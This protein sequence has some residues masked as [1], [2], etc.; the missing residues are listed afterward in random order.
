MRIYDSK[1]VDAFIKYLN[2]LPGIEVLPTQP[3]PYLYFK[4]RDNSTET[5]EPLYGYI[6]KNNK[7]RFTLVHEALNDWKDWTLNQR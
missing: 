3:N 4:Y 2:D 7:G 6:Y 5:G 1:R